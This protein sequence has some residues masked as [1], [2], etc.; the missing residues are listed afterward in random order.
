MTKERVDL[1]SLK[2]NK[3][4][5]YGILSLCI[6]ILNIILSIAIFWTLWAYI[7]SK[8]TETLYIQVQILNIGSRLELI[9][10]PIGVIFGIIG[11]CQKNNK[12]YIA[13]IGVFINIITILASVIVA[14][15]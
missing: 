7:N 1:I 2:Q 14:F 13:I 8:Y 5:F 3:V 6:G 11:L 12:K 9:L 4:A 10:K 15:S